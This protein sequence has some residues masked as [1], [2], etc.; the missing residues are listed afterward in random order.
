MSV[1]AGWTSRVE[2]R[3]DLTSPDPQ[4]GVETIS[5]AR[6]ESSVEQNP[7]GDLSLNREQGW[8]PPPT[9]D[10]FVSDEHPTR[11]VAAFVDGLD[12]SSWADMKVDKD[13][14]S[15]GA[16]ADNLR[17]T[18]SFEQS[19]VQIKREYASPSPMPFVSQMGTSWG[20]ANN[21]CG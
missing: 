9:L 13:G 20:V 14:N 16:P 4:V 17:C 6:T 11:F 10:E 1:P 5:A 15:L 2:L 18:R 21:I 12:R 7:L 8:L 19:R 3:L